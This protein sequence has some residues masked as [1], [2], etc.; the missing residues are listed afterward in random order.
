MYGR[1]KY[2]EFRELSLKIH[3]IKIQ[4]ISLLKTQMQ[5]E[6]FT[7]N[8]EKF[9]TR[10]GHHKLKWTRPNVGGKSPIKPKKTAFRTARET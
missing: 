10:N 1:R 5:I 6:T 4:P 3:K 9:L 7:Q 2:A 8:S